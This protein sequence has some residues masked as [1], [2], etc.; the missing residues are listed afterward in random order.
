MRKSTSRKDTNDTNDH[1]NTDL[2]MNNT[3][4][5][6]IYPDLSFQL[7][8]LCMFVHNT[9]GQFCREKQY[10]QY[11]EQLLVDKKINYKKEVEIFDTKNRADFIIENKIVIELKSKKMMHS[12]DYNQ[13]Q[14]YL[15]ATQLKLGLLINFG[16]KDLFY[17]RITLIET[18]ARKR[19]Q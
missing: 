19:F 7:V 8:G 4:N 10:S 11:L 14:R 3:N 12:E 15:Q 5:N 6:L 17:K 18:D 1:T 2:N 9:Y 16:G 13:I